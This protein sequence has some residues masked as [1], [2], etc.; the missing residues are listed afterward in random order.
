M[1]NEIN[2]DLLQKIND[3]LID[4]KELIVV[5]GKLTQPQKQSTTDGKGIYY[6]FQLRVL[7]KLGIDE[8]ATTFNTYHCIIPQDV[9]KRYSDDEISSFKDN[10]VICLMSAN[11]RTK[12]LDNGA[13]VN[14][15][16]FFVNDMVLIRTIDNNI[17]STK[18]IKL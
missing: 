9:A 4:E 18:V 10:E 13:I 12:K 17:N 14:N 7:K 5:K 11:C 3:M 6:S 8:Y 1:K 16:T 2:I 15:I